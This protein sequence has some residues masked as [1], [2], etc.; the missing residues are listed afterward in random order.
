MRGEESLAGVTT[1]LPTGTPPRA[2]GRAAAAWSRCTVRGNT[3]TCVG[4]SVF[5]DVGQAEKEEHPHVRGEESGHPT[6]PLAWPG[7]PPRAWGRVAC[8]RHNW[9]ASGNTPT[10]VGKRSGSTSSVE[11]SRE[12]PHVRGEESVKSLKIFQVSRK[13]PIQRAQ[14]GQDLQR[15]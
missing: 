7:T 6:T 14:K 8:G 9:L 13:N 15:K 3:P 11:T 4:K 2:W 12:H 1:G 10:C 5:P